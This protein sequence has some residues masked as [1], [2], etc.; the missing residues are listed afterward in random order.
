MAINGSNPKR[1][2]CPEGRSCPW[3]FPKGGKR[4]G[5]RPQ[6]WTVRVRAKVQGMLEQ[7]AALE[8][9]A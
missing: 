2:G 4:A 3:C 9:E 5:N 7:L 8:G 6:R 1:L